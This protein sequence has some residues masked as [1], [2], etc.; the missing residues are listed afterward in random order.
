MPI[1]SWN[2]ARTHTSMCH[3]HRRVPVIS[4]CFPWLSFPCASCLSPVF[5]SLCL[6][7][8]A[9]S[10]PPCSPEPHSCQQSTHQ[11]PAHLPRLSFHSS[12]DRCSSLRGTYTQA[13][14]FIFLNFTSVHT[15]ILSLLHTS[16]SI[17]IRFYI[18]IFHSI[19]L[20]FILYTI[21]YSHILNFCTI[22]YLM[23]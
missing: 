7:V 17:S 16:M 1:N 8:C 19:V 22:L 9:K 20:Y 18:L 23:S 3:G 15:S 14:I 5:L 11:L 12:P 21:F 13:F 10:L 4:S 6:C 2:H